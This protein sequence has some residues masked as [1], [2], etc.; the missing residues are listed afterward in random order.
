MH[1][2]ALRIDRDF[3]AGYSEAWTVLDYPP[4]YTLDQAGAEA[5]AA[6]DQASYVPVEGVSSEWQAA[7]PC[8]CTPPE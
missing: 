4:P 6:A 2:H 8:D 7:G 5:M 1:Y 3:R